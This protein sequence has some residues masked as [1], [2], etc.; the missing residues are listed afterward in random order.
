[1]SGL[2]QIGPTA[3]SKIKSSSEKGQTFWNV[4]S[5]KS[6]KKSNVYDFLQKNYWLNRTAALLI[7]RERRINMETLI[8][9]ENMSKSYGKKQVP[10]S[11]NLKVEKGQILGLVGPNGAGKTTCLHSIL[12]LTSCQGDID[13]LGFSPSKQRTSMLKN[14]A[15]ISDVAVLPKWMKVSQSIEYM[16]GIHPNFRPE[17]AM[18]FLACMFDERKDL[19][20][21][22]WRSLPINDALVIAS[23]VFT[24]AIVIPVFY[25]LAA[26]LTI[27]G[28]ISVYSLTVL[29]S[30]IST[31][32]KL[33]SAIFEL[34]LTSN[35]FGVWLALIPLVLWL[36]PLFAWLMLAS[37]FAQRAPFLW[38]VLPILLIGLTETLMWSVFGYSSLGISKALSDYFLPFAS[39]GNVSIN[40]DFMANSEH[41]NYLLA[42][43]VTDQLS[44]LAVLIGSVF[45]V[46]TY[47]L[48]VHR[49][50]S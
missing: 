22:F 14:L 47:F 49:S 42:R 9:I 44:V 4:N 23:K 48:R 8:S 35:I 31:D 11:V 39:L 32:G 17:K 16:K 19:S 20:I 5:L 40:A 1:M 6:K 28:S 45:L 36:F 10:K 38:A 46:G 33:L 18:E 27:L 25:L 24:G 26:M 34:N 15:Y 37:A 3:C 2:R 21:F 43:T 30:D 13:V 12:G 29:F 7:N 50:N 41:A